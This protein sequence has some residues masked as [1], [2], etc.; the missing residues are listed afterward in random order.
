LDKFTGLSELLRISEKAQ[1]PVMAKNGSVFPKGKMA[2]DFAH[3]L[4]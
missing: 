4:E 1:L 2:K 3:L